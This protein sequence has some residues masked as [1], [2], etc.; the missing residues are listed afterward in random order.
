M[1]TE[2][3]SNDVR[4]VVLQRG[5]VVVGRWTQTP[6]SMQVTLA[7]SSIVRQWGTTKGLGE[8]TSGPT[9]KT[10]LDAAGEI[11]FHELT[12]V[13]SMKCDAAKWEKHLG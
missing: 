1:D 9:N 7:D 12:V 6:G 13:L 10:V 11:K 3:K 2:E 8:I 4:I 5:F